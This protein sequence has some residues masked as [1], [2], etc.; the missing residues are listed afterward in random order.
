M[1]PTI[2][3]TLVQKQT[4]KIDPPIKFKD[5]IS[6][7]QVAV[8]KDDDHASQVQPLCE[9]LPL[10]ASPAPCTREPYLTL[11]LFPQQVRPAL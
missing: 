8:W 3:I 6:V 11:Q 10:P 4:K 5:D 2:I 1:N 9:Q 7:C